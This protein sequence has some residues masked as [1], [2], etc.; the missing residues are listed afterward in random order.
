MPR[1][2]LIVLPVLLLGP[3]VRATAQTPTSSLTGDATYRL[4]CASCHGSRGHGDG[5]LAST[6]RRTP[7]DL[8]TLAAS[9][10][11]HFPADLVAQVIDGR[12]PA[13]GHG[14]GEMPVWGDAFSRSDEHTPVADRIGRVVRYL[15]SL[16]GR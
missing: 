6:L 11:G 7:R 9:N 1:L 14:G 4:Y 13:K 12:K 3:A 2:A 15:E 16:Q 10:G 5:P 8:T